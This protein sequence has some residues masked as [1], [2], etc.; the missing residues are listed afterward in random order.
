MESFSVILVVKIDA[1]MGGRYLLKLCFVF[2]GKQGKAQ[3]KTVN[4]TKF[5]YSTPKV[6]D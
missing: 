6:T 2:T 5:S 1:R 4:N 3:N